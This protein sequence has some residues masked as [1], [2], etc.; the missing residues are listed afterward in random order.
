MIVAA[1]FLARLKFC[2]KIS[3]LL[4]SPDPIPRGRS[5]N[6]CLKLCE[7]LL[8]YLWMFWNL[9]WHFAKSGQKAGQRGWV[10]LVE[11]WV[12]LENY[13]SP[14]SSSHCLTY[15]ADRWPGRWG[16]RGAGGSLS[17][18]QG[19]SMA[20]MGHFIADFLQQTTVSSHRHQDSSS[21]SGPCPF[22]LHVSRHQDLKFG[23]ECLSVQQEASHTT[24]PES[25]WSFPI[26]SSAPVSDLSSWASWQILGSHESY[27]LP[28]G[29]AW[30]GISSCSFFFFKQFWTMDHSW[31]F[32]RWHCQLPLTHLPFH[33]W[34]RETHVCVA[35][36]RNNLNSL[37]WR[38]SWFG[39][40]FSKSHKDKQEVTM[41]PT[42][43]FNKRES[44]PHQWR[45][46]E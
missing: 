37:K 15:I 39:V 38:P 12:V 40:Y 10:L 8:F 3:T 2:A 44:P 41:Q 22:P 29:S 20:F 26:V 19:L 42:L 25:W 5:L 9:L 35:Q 31:V 1:I 17:R 45:G 46:M 43:A 11:P 30:T 13:S 34:R 28:T 21:V 36:A 33:L 32:H 7:R 16:R 14:K 27:N 4:A 23:W 18:S 24:P 6:K